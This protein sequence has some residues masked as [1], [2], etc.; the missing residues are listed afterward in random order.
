[1]DEQKKRLE[2]F[3][4]SRGWE[5]FEFFV[6]AGYSGSNMERPALQELIQRITEFDTILVYKLD[7]LGR[8]Q[9]E[10]LYLIEDVF[11]KNNVNFNSIT[12]NFD[13]STPVGKLM[14]SMMGA[15]AELERQQIN[16][17][18]M[19]GRIASAEKGRWRGGS[20]VPTGYKYIPMPQGGDGNLQIDEGKAIVVKDIFKMLIEG[21]SYTSIND[22]YHFSGSGVVRQ[23]LKNP[24]YIGKIKY[25]GELYD[26]HHEPIIDQETF[27][28]AQA[29]IHE[30]EVKRNFPSLKERHLLT[31]FLR[32]SCGARACYH[33]AYQKKKDGTKR[34]YEYYEC[35]TRMAHGTMR[36]A[37]KCHNKIWRKADLEE[38]VWNVLEELDYEEV[39]KSEPKV[40]TSPLEKK[41]KKIE[42]Q[43]SKLVELYSLE[44]IPLDIL[45]TQ[46]SALN[47]QKETLLEQIN[48]EHN[49]MARM[50]EY[51]VRKSLSSVE[52]I[53]NA[54]LK[55][56]RAFLGSLIEE[57]IL[58]PNHD[59]KFKW[60]F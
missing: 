51:E 34:R 30:R 56:Q 21:H 18:M 43:I 54:D 46:L 29:I 2:A 44:D 12:E 50:D 20:G 32:C 16:E 10:I 31:G 6:D 25:C 38:V 27:D 11:G 33:N 48:L 23:I 28:K 19:M 9:R 24:V 26:G 35:Y 45:T 55:T 13:T 4:E 17:R 36:A 42:K 39:K 41:V 1:V 53:K 52:K 7:R 49:K 47:S 58:L 14:L 40:D 15:F 60:K 59:L 22:K 37:E 8:N 3:C 5:N 57:I